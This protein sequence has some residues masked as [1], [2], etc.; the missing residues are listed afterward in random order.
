[1]ILDLHILLAFEDSVKHSNL[2]HLVRYRSCPLELRPIQL[3][4]WL[5][6]PPAAIST[7]LKDSVGHMLHLS[8]FE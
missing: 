6:P 2:S 8:L 5:V 1:M 4:V 3:A 7:A